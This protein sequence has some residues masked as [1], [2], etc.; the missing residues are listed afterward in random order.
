MPWTDDELKVLM[1]EVIEG[2]PNAKCIHCG[3]SFPKTELD[4]W[5]DCPKHTARLEVDRLR[6]E[7]ASLR[8]DIAK[9]IGRAAGALM[10]EYGND[11]AKVRISDHACVVVKRE[12]S[13]LFHGAKP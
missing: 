5:R 9:A 11:D 6:A 4:H 1:K 2:D 3:G 10:V 12:I 8:D 13:Q 7:F